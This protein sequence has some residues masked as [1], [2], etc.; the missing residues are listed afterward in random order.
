MTTQI[1]KSK[2]FL[3][4]GSLIIW[5]LLR[6]MYPEILISSPLIPLG[7]A[8]GIYKNK[9]LIPLQV[10]SILQIFLFLSPHILR[11]SRVSHL[12]LLNSSFAVG[13]AIVTIYLLLHIVHKC[14]PKSQNLRIL[15][16]ISLLVLLTITNPPQLSQSQFFTD[17]IIATNLH[18]RWLV[19]PALFLC[20][21]TPRLHWPWIAKLSPLW[22]PLLFNSISIH[23][24]PHE[25]FNLLSSK[26]PEDQFLILKRIYWNVLFLI[27]SALVDFLVFNNTT[28]FLNWIS[29]D[30]SLQLATLT[31][32]ARNHFK[33]SD[34]WW[35]HWVQSAAHIYIFFSY[36]AALG[37]ISIGFS[38]LC[39]YQLPWNFTL[40]QNKKMSF[41]WSQ[42]I[43]FFNYIAYEL[44]FKSLMILL[45]N[46]SSK[47]HRIYL[48]IY[49]TVIIFGSLFFHFINSGR[50][51]QFNGHLWGGRLLYLSIIA[52][53]SIGQIKYADL[54]KTKNT[55]IPLLPFLIRFLIIG[56]LLSIFFNFGLLTGAN[57]EVGYL[58]K[59]YFQSFL[60]I[61]F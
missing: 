7:L 23:P 40:V 18:F 28:H 26:N 20:R 30:Y 39:G 27:S 41:R 46:V 59:E 43:F 44:V 8:I 21:E 61:L 32:F 55:K 19:W 31:S 36:W 60:P 14:I 33:S 17:L 48:S 15:S 52:I 22:N 12:D 45:K 34:Q 35:I 24:N 4:I 3:L 13:L 37:N 11:G 6:F 54:V 58:Y 51:V 9:T 16:M 5:G 49:L 56:T 50:I 47:L 42:I 1:A 53:I 38:R 29:P 25:N 2:S 10:L 57:P